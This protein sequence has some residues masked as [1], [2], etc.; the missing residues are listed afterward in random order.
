MES[1]PSLEYIDLLVQTRDIYSLMSLYGVCKTVD[2]YLN[3]ADVLDN[4]IKYAEGDSSI[5]SFRDFIIFY[6]IKTIISLS[7]S[8]ALEFVLLFNYSFN[9]KELAEKISKED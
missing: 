6:S 1:C 7:P 5:K 8:N 3:K 9:I 4:L 2:D